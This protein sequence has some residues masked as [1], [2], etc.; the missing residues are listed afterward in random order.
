V[1]GTHAGNC[2]PRHELQ[3]AKG[4][5]RRN[6][7]IAAYVQAIARSDNGGGRLTPHAVEQAPANGLS[8]LI[9]GYS[10][11]MLARTRIDC[12]TLR[13][14]AFAAATFNVSVNFP[15]CSMGILLAGVPFSTLSTKTATVL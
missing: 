15:S 8:Q 14:S 2:P 13:P 11:T 4:S 1:T 5:S 10:I 3:A 6:P 9:V 7:R 12:G